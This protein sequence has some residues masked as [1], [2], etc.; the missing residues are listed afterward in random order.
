MTAG[1]LSAL[2]KVVLQ[3]ERLRQAEVKDAKLSAMIKQID[4]IK[5]RLLEG[6]PSSFQ[7]L[8]N[9]LR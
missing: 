4:K 2:E 8:L 3:I 1:D 9:I 6:V 5:V 7:L